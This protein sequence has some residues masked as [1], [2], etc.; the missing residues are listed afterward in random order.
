MLWRSHDVWHNWKCFYSVILCCCRPLSSFNL[1]TQNS[2]CTRFCCYLPAMTTASHGKYFEGSL[3][4]LFENFSNTSNK[5]GDGS[6][7]RRKTSILNL[8]ILLSINLGNII[9]A[10]RVMVTKCLW[11]QCSPFED[12]Y[13]Y[14]P[15]TTSANREI[16]YINTVNTYI[17]ETLFYRVCGSLF[18]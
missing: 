3:I 10:I 15:I 17:K 1:F 6:S 5:C 14:I 7:L 9:C 12:F 13:N 11:K 8:Q 4:V 2:H 16:T 18:Y